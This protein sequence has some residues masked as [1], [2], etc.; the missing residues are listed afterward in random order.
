MSGAA[1]RTGILEKKRKKKEN[2]IKKVGC[3]KKTPIIARIA[4]T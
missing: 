4:E 1:A 2:K 3:V